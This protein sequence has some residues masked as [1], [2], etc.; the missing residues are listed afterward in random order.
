MLIDSKLINMVVVRI[1]K[2]VETFIMIFGCLV[3]K[4]T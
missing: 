3:N 2:F 1:G 4:T